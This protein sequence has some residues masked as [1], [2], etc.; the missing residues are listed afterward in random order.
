[1]TIKGQHVQ[2]AAVFCIPLSILQQTLEAE[3]RGS[4]GT[5]LSALCAHVIG[6]QMA[7]VAYRSGLTE[8]R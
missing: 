3:W 4:I 7:T 2:G 5:R 8:A 6:S 1:M